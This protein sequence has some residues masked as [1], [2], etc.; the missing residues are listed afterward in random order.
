[1][2]AQPAI[3]DVVHS[4]RG[5]TF[6]RLIPRKDR[7]LGWVLADLAEAARQ[8]GKYAQKRGDQQTKRP[9]AEPPERTLVRQGQRLDHSLFQPER[10]GHPLPRQKT[11]RGFKHMRSTTLA[12]GIVAA[13]IAKPAG[14][15][16]LRYSTRVFWQGDAHCRL[17][18]REQPVIAGHIPKE[19]VM[20]FEIANLV[21]HLILDF[22]SMAPMLQKHVGIANPDT[23]G[24]AIPLD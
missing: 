22:V 21:L 24:I 13:Y 11:S 4:G 17:I 6:R 18:N 5:Q 8:E 10:Y 20:G 2:P 15:R 3:V 12:V 1:M 14:I 9:V 23:E 16:V 19:L 7:I